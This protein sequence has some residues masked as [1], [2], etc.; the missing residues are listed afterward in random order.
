MTTLKKGT[1]KALISM[2]DYIQQMIDEPPP[3]MVGEAATP[4]SSH[5]FEVNESNP[6]KLDEKQSMMFHHNVAKL[7]FL[8]K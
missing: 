2:K 7:L 1:G 4:T 5:L 8:C 6:T 3:D